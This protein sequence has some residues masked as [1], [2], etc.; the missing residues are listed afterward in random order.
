MT[1]L[2][3]D[4]C[5]NNQVRQHS[6]ALPLEPQPL[7]PQHEPGQSRQGHTPTKRTPGRDEQYGR[8]AANSLLTGTER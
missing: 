8:L 4:P 6:A 3:L 1:R 5:D 2:I 7:P